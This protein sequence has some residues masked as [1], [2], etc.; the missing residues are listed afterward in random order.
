ME[1]QVATDPIFKKIL[2]NLGVTPAFM[3]ELQKIHDAGFSEEWHERLANF[4]KKHKLTIP[5]MP[6]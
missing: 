1:N 4:A 6:S 2:E 3:M 5:E